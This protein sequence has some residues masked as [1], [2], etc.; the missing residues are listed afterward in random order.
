[1]SALIRNCAV[2]WYN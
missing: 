2:G 1:M